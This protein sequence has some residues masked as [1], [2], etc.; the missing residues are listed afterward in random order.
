MFLIRSINGEIAS[1]LIF[2][3]CYVL[4]RPETKRI[5]ARPIVSEGPKVKLT[6]VAE[7]ES[8]AFWDLMN[9]AA[10]ELL[11]EEETEQFLAALRQVKISISMQ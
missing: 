3:Y 9:A 5:E 6:K 11:S 10:R 4:Q 7:S 8:K 1:L 2:F